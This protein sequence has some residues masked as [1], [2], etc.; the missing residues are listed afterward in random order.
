M[1]ET[2]LERWHIPFFFVRSKNGKLP[3]LSYFDNFRIMGAVPVGPTNLFKLFSSKSHV[4]LYPGGV[5]EAF[6]RKVNPNE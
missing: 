3:D 6:H 1:K 2:S 4:L 5:R